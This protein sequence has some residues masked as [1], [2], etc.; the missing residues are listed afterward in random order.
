[1]SYETITVTPISS[2]I[3]ARIDGVDL[4]SLS[5]EQFAEIHRALIEHLVIVLPGQAIND[6]AQKGFAGRFGTCRPHPVREFFGN[7]E[8][9]AFVENSADK[10]PQ[11]DNFW[12][13]DYSF[14]PEIPDVAV[15]QAEIVPATG[16]DTM[17]ANMY[18]AYEGLSESLRGYIGGLRAFHDLGPKFEFEMQ[19][20]LGD[21][22]AAKIVAH[23][24]GAEHPLVTSHPVTGRK[25]L[26]VNQGY[27]RHIVGLHAAESDALLNFL[28]AHIDSPTYHC[29]YRW[30]QG[31]VAVWDERATLHQGPAD[32]FPQHRK[33]RRVTA[34]SNAPLLAS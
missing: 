27:T 32:F 26:F 14:N 16:G 24:K 1:M 34:G 29:R 23:F 19:R 15:L 9:L 6:E 4:M 3:G 8:T 25:V 30:G 22:A 7:T 18:A 10:P 33:L 20:T 13:T 11:T 21:E 17:W 28:F 2:S 12:H 31:D 5:D